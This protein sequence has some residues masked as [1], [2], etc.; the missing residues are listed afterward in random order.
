M[1]VATYFDQM[2]YG[3]APEADTEA[4]DWL[5]RYGAS[6]GHF[7]NGDFR[8]STS[9]KTFVTHE[10]ATGA[11]LATLAIGSAEDVDLAVAAARKAQGPWSKL[12]G[13]QRARHLY[14][15]ARMIQRHGRLLAVVEAIDNGK[16][17]RETRDIDIP[18]AARHFYH[19][20]GWAQLQETE[21]SDHN[22][23]GVVGQIIPWN[24]PLLMLA[25]K[26]APALALG[27]TVV[28][29]PAEFTSLTA[30]LFAELA[31]AAGLPP[32]VLNVITGEGETGALVVDH[33]GIDK[34]AFTGSTEVGRIIREK[35]AGSGK[36]LT[37]EL[38]GKSPFIVFDD[39]DIDGAVE[40]VV[41]AIWFNQGQ[42]C[43]AGSRVLVQEGIAPKFHARL[44]RRMQ[45]LRVGH[46]LDKAIDMGAIVAPVQLKRIE[47][48]VNQGVSEGAELYQSDIEL[49]KVGSYYKPTLLANV[50][51]TSIVATEEIFG[52]VAV[53]MTFRT[54]EEA[55]QLAN[56]TR[57]GL[58]ASVWSET[59]GLALHVA[60]KLQ[61]GVVWVN[62]TNLFDASAGFGGKKES[63]FGREGGKEGAYEYLKPKAWANLK[64]RAEIAAP[65]LKTTAGDFAAPLI[66]RT[67]KLYVG[68]KQA[69]PDGNYSRPILSPKGKVV[70]E[71]GEGNRKDIRNAVAAAQA[72]SSWA[73]ATAH[74]RA[75]ILYYIAENL[76]SREDEFAAR[77]MAQTGRS[78]SSSK[79]EVDMSIS[80]LFTYGA[81][82]DKYEGLVHTP[83][84]RG[85]AL[86]LPEPQ[87]VVGVICPPEAPLL[88][89]ISL[90]APLIAVGNRVV[91]VPSEPYP[92]S[93]TDFYTV[94]ETSDV[95]GG[96][97]NIV[98]GSAVELGKALASHND[99]DALWAFG[100]PALSAM[101][102]KASTG[103][104]KRVFTD[105]GK[106]FDWMDPVQGEGPLFL[107]RATDVKNVW[108]PYGE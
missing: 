66:D 30:L 85:V 7:I 75:Q 14:A 73:G 70:G 103:N 27:N 88:G 32:G 24:F 20:A 8:P 55:V 50:Q 37:L 79:A 39:A 76:A 36:S 82:A 83:P 25:W 15:L 100:S 95:P 33:P 45:T 102:E 52:P 77:I 28:L 51:P 46:P 67:A 108:I 16:P 93:A 23:V 49:P 56:H 92:L 81:W 65:Q 44:R 35:T 107:R 104:L 29:K 53:S 72:A 47:A 68:G 34:I 71:V 17:V 60:A 91:A 19:H 99:V 90:V 105:Y 87:G 86:A 43:C 3:P 2:S 41:D 5:K 80:R 101:A 54:P 31:A 62:A 1:S 38:G 4:R 84:L 74:N 63:G 57:Y 89:F 59:I 26:V 58:A 10:P 96:V 97:L 40:G 78:A 48:L 13:H 61:A 98:T 64:P 21:F 6:F 22:P 42:V 9:A 94:L 11:Q 69:R 106:A 12:S 18:L